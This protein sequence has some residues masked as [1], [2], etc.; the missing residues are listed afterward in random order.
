M[1]S[2]NQDS[3]VGR[4]LRAVPL[5]GCP[6]WL[7]NLRRNAES[8]DLSQTSQQTSPLSSGARSWASPGEE[9]FLLG[10][11][12]GQQGAQGGD[13]CVC[14]GAP[15]RVCWAQGSWEGTETCVNTPVRHLPP[16]RLLFTFSW[17]EGLRPGFSGLSGRAHEKVPVPSSGSWGR[18]TPVPVYPH[19][20]PPNR[21]IEP[22]T[23]RWVLLA[24]DVSQQLPGP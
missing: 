11:L 14:C 12:P 15:L 9:W 22:R 20:P 23:Q 7:R 10:V 24:I 2:H 4:A 19:T 16:G 18:C 17:A 8:S 6:G 21:P 1:S 13:E 3:Q 5:P